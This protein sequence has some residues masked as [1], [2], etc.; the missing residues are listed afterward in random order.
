[1]TRGSDHFVRRSETYWEVGRVSLPEY[2]HRLFWTYTNGAGRMT[3]AIGQNW[4]GWEN[5]DIPHGS[6]QWTILQ[7]KVSEILAPYLKREGASV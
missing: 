7:A 3:W 2:P 1:M 4:N 5:R 6:K